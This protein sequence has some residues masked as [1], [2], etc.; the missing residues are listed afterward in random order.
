MRILWG[1][2]EARK[3]SERLGTSSNTPST[4]LTTPSAV[5]ATPAPTPVGTANPPHSTKSS[6]K[7]QRE[8]T[9][10]E[11]AKKKQKLWGGV[12]A[13]WRSQDE[14]RG[15]KELQFYDA[16]IKQTGGVDRQWFFVE[17][18]IQDD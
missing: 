16:C 7:R 15:Y 10:K 8:A 12:E 11:E 13:A 14:S 1:G 18:N 9:E 6:R 2:L 4:S 5:S 3:R 17:T